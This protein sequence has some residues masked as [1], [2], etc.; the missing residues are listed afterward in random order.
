MSTTTL[1]HNFFLFFFSVLKK[2][3]KNFPS[4]LLIRPLVDQTGLKHHGEAKVFMTKYQTTGPLT[5]R[6]I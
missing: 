4:M 1:N 2:S 3:F 6:V 5:H